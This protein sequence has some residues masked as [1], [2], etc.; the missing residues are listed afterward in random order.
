MKS[1]R[2]EEVH[3]R[4]EEESKEERKRREEER[5]KERK[6]YGRRE[7]EGGEIG[8]ESIR[9]PDRESWIRARTDDLD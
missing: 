5:G 1:G 2:P 4:W 9:L 6:E 7:E 8:A 3:A